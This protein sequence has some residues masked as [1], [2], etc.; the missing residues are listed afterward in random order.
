MAEKVGPAGGKLPVRRAMRGKLP[1]AVTEGGKAR[2]L[3]HAEQFQIGHMDLTG[4]LA[5]PPSAARRFIDV[6]RLGLALKEA[7]GDPRLWWPVC[8]LLWLRRI[9]EGRW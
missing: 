5:D 4:V 2:G 8:F 9:D 6:G 1:A 3:G 7:P